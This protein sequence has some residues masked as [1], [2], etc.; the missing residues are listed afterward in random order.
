MIILTAQ[1]MK[2]NFMKTMNIVKRYG[3][4]AS[5]AAMTALP[6]LVFAAGDISDSFTA[7]AG[8]LK[9]ALLAIGALVVGVVVVGV[10]FAAGIG[11]FRKAK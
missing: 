4:K 9:T 5:V 11:L 8:E 2:G 6:V 1:N 3:A 10:S 7:P